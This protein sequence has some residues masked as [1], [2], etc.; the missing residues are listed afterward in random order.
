MRTKL[1]H[2][3]VACFASCA[4]A[5]S[6][7]LATSAMAAPEDD[8]NIYVLMEALRAPMGSE[9]AIFQKQ[10]V[11]DRDTQVNVTLRNYGD[12]APRDLVFDFA[13]PDNTN[14]VSTGSAQCTLR[15]AQFA[16]CQLPSLPAESEAQFDFTVNVASSTEASV[17]FQGT[18]KSKTDRAEENFKFNIVSGQADL[19]VTQKPAQTYKGV[20]GGVDGQRWDVI[21]TNHSNTSIKNVDVFSLWENKMTN[22]DIS[23]SWDRGEWSNEDISCEQNAAEGWWCTADELGP[24]QSVTIPIEI[25]IDG[26]PCPG[27]A[28]TQKVWIGPFVTDPVVDNN[29]HTATA[30]VEHGLDIDQCPVSE[31]L[32]Y[33]FGGNNRFHTAAILSFVYYED[34]E[35]VYLASG[36]D[37]PD[38]LAASAAAASK[39][40]PVLL[41]LP[42]K[43]SDEA[44]DALESANPGRVVVVGGPAA[45]SDSVIAQVKAILPQAQ[46]ERMGGKNRFVTAAKIAELT[47]PA[48]ERVFIA[49]GM[50]F[51]DALSAAAA[52]GSKDAPVLLSTRDE[53]PEESAAILRK[54]QPKRVVIVG[55]EG[56]VSAKAAAQIQAAAKGVTPIRYGGAN[57]FETG[58]LVALGEFEE[59]PERVV[60]ANAFDYPDALVG[61]AV[62][63]WFDSPVLLTATNEL[64]QDTVQALRKLVPNNGL[65]VGGEGV[66][67]QRVLNDFRIVTG[68]RQAFLMLG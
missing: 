50:D 17:N 60:L 30:A 56:V 53:F 62:A 32:V 61:A 34:P 45:V 44:K 40:S 12:N 51:P 9:H 8:Q 29:Y 11:T 54:L 47:F 55:G 26:L 35:V 65:I 20:P 10:I 2:P 18:L 23:L 66:I 21:I 41:T 64:P 4:L 58:R 25:S 1:K 6:S 59:H 19:S 49:S 43:L 68:M 63:G 67:S 28:L 13:V 48:A 36:L 38:A 7:A 3:I 46:V 39:T 42:N 52:A 57:R 16:S 22:S 27:S 5:A 14:I 33:R 15:D 31:G 24:N 37:Y